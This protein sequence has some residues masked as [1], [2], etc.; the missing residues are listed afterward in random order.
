MLGNNETK[1]LL[2]VSRPCV[3][4]SRR[5]DYTAGLVWMHAAFVPEHFCFCHLLPFFACEEELAGAVFHQGCYL[6]HSMLHLSGTGRA[7]R[8][9]RQENKRRERKG[10]R[11]RKRVEGGEGKGEERERE[12]GEG[13]VGEGEAVIREV[14]CKT[15]I[16]CAG[17]LVAGVSYL[18]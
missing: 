10:L 2:Y 15:T 8:D 9:C 18:Q 17:K 3:N 16:C 5:I 11:S 7:Q 14:G 6:L 13:E 1:V 12:E 4:R